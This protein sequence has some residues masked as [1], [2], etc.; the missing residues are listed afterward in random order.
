MSMLLRIAFMRLGKLRTSDLQY[1]EVI[2]VYHTC[3]NILSKSI[4]LILGDEQK[5]LLL[6]YSA[7]F[8]FD[9]LIIN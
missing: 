9:A 3:L 1:C 8:V 6:L 5:Y 2:S 7:V 4:L